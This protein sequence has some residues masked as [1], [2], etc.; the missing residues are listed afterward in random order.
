MSRKFEKI[1]LEE[2][3]KLG[4]AEVW[5][6]D[7]ELPKR[8]TKYSAGYD[9]HVP[10]NMVLKAKETLKIPTL[11]KADME[12]NNVLLI[13]VRSSLGFKHNV[14][15]TNTIAVI[16]KDYYNNPDNEGHIFIKLYNPND[17]DIVFKANERI[18]QGI[19][20]RYDITDDDVADAERTGGIGSTN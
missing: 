13:D 12:E 7:L 6:N 9:I 4:H 8:A 3:N 20:V 14:R 10:F 2:F 18:A 1:S 15:L 16:D 11:L 17:Y 5:Y 19:F